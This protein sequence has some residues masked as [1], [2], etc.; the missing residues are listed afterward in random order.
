VR[1]TGG[2]TPR[3][4]EVLRLVAA[5]LTDNQIA[6]HLYLSPETIYS[7]MRSIR[8][9]LGVHTRAGAVATGFRLGLLH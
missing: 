7:H 4:V 5:D 3:Q 2:L 8:K 9:I 1:R 6:Q